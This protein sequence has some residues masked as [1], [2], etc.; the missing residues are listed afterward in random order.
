MLSETAKGKREAT[1]QPYV[2]LL[3]QD[4]AYEMINKAKKIGIHTDVD[5]D[6]FMSFMIIKKWLQNSKKKLD[7][8]YLNKGKEHGALGM[9]FMQVREIDLLIVLD[10]STNE[11]PEIIDKVQ[12]QNSECR[13]LIIDHHEIKKGAILEVAS[14]NSETLGVVVN[15]MTEN[16]KNF[17]CGSLV[18]E[19]IRAHSLSSEMTAENL[20][21][22]Q[23]ACISLFTDS[24]EMDN[25]RNL[26]YAYKTFY[27]NEVE[28][29]VAD[30]IKSFNIYG[31][32]VNKSAILFKIAPLFNKAIRANYSMYALQSLLVNT[33]E[34]LNLEF[35]AEIQKEYIE[36]AISAYQFN[37][38]KCIYFNLTDLG[39]PDTYCGVIASKLSSLYNR[40]VICTVYTDREHYLVKG[41]FR[42][43]INGYPY[44]RKAVEEG[45][46]EVAGHD[47]AFGTNGKEDM[48]HLMLNNITKEEPNRVDRIAY[49]LLGTTGEFD[50]IH[51]NSEA[52]WNTLKRNGALVELARANS[53]VSVG[54]QEFIRV[55]RASMKYIGV[56]EKKTMWTYE[57][58]DMEVACFEELGMC[59]EV[60]IYPEE[61]HNGIKFYIR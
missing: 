37:G 13:V 61:V 33:D 27:T 34:L 48:V 11:L 24:I 49:Y 59:S 25:P 44:Y 52:E 55:P 50:G 47:K 21:L 53:V 22:Y 41:S 29:T 2:F 46:A 26:W 12:G 54:E 30:L 14:E 8:V 17:S 16:D 36:K 19:F 7:K 23:L 45:L 15:N 56:N 9:D 32:K 58:L 18:Y 10:S 20:K 39:I 60:N 3:N 5:L 38:E 28:S 6:G 31:G 42:G 43:L 1:K 57:V 40:S 51:V 4:K 35:C